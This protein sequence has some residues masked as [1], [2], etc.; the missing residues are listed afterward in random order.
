MITVIRKE[1]IVL[2]R[3]VLPILLAFTLFPMM[4]YLLILLPMQ[5][6]VSSPSGVNYLH[7]ASPGIWVVASSVVSMLS[8][9]LVLNPFYHREDMSEFFLRASL[10]NHNIILGGI[11]W[12]VIMGLVQFL[13]S[14]F[15]TTSLN[16]MLLNVLEFFQVLVYIIPLLILFSMV[17]AVFGM[18]VKEEYLISL[19]S[20][21]V[22]FFLGFGSGCFVP[23]VPEQSG[24][25]S[26][27]VNSPIY[28]DVGCLHSIVQNIS[29][30]ISPPIF[31]ILIS[32]FLYFILVVFSHR[33]FRS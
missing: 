32:V 17:G 21:M 23:I 3:N 33:M 25:P 31:L 2:K 18:F 1:F 16:G 7:W 12:S 10:S 14:F 27:I 4:M 28:L 6:Y 22:F 11:V 26:F 5:G 30:N 29:P 13:V 19:F 9:L 24:L 8:C 15:I 20:V